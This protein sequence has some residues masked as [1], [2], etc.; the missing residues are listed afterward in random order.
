[1]RLLSVVPG[2][3]PETR[4]MKAECLRVARSKTSG[5]YGNCTDLPLA[6]DKTL[7]ASAHIT[8]LK[9][10]I[11]HLE[12]WQYLLW[13]KTTGACFQ[14]T[15]LDQTCPEYLDTVIVIVVIAFD[16]W[17][18]PTIR[19]YLV[20]RPDMLCWYSTTSVLNNSNISCDLCGRSS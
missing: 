3:Y 5:L 6:D 16:K 19:L 9:F 15:E 20:R 11:Q 8:V 1:M 10:D 4:V 12:T 17:P 2:N 7:P 14:V 13:H 18:L